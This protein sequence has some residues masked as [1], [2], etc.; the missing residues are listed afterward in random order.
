MNRNKFHSCL[1]STSICLERC[2][3]EWLSGYCL[4]SLAVHEWKLHICNQIKSVPC[5]KK[6][7]SRTN[8]RG[9]WSDWDW[10]WSK[11]EQASPPASVIFFIDQRLVVRRAPLGVRGNLRR[12]ALI[13]HPATPVAFSIERSIIHFLQFTLQFRIVYWFLCL[14]MDSAERKG[15]EEPKNVH[16]QTKSNPLRVFNSQLPWSMTR[17][18]WMY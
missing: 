14:L 16:K 17:S 10:G 13:S 3:D 7:S 12:P 9:T 15:N 2:S 1:S 8:H 4:A 5:L 11:L 6:K 18:L